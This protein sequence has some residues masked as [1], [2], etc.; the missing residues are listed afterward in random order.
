VVDAR[1]PLSHAREHLYRKIRT[2]IDIKERGGKGGHVKW[3]T[4]AIYCSYYMCVVCELLAR[5]WQKRR[6]VSFEDLSCEDLQRSVFEHLRA[7]RH[8]CTSQD[9]A[10]VTGVRFISPS[11]SCMRESMSALSSV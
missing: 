5:G 8:D 7:E 3:F 4:R 2:R 10:V 11:V 9:L 6:G 1:R